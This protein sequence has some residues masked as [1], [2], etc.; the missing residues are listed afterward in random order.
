MWVEMMTRRRGL[1]LQFLVFVIGRLWRR[2][3]SDILNGG[4]Q[5]GKTFADAGAGFDDEVLAID[6]RPLDGLGHRELLRAMLVGRQPGGDAAAGAEDGR[7]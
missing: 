4:N 1:S 2:I 3:G 7:G 6:Q 5:I